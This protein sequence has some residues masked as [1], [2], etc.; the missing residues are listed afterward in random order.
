[1]QTSINNPSWFVTGRSNRDMNKYNK[2]T[3]RE[4]DML[5]KHIRQQEADKLHI[6]EKLTKMKP[7]NVKTNE[8]FS[9]VSR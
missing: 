3:D 8:A 9:A 1:M 6:V 4:M 5:N 7:Q 2:K